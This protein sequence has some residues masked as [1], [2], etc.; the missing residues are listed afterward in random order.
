MAILLTDLLLGLKKE[1]I[2]QLKKYVRS[3]FVTHR[4]D[5]AELFNVYADC[6][7]QGKSF[8]EKVELFEIIY[9]KEPFDDQKMR[10]T[11]SDL[12]KVVE[13][14]LTSAIIQGDETEKNLLLLR[15]YRQRNREKHF[16]KTAQRIEKI[17]ARQ[18]LRNPDYYDDQ[19]R[20][21]SES[22]MF[23][24]TNR[25]AGGLHLQE[26]GDTMDILYLSRKLRHACTQLSHRA[27]F[28]TDYDFGLLNAW[29][30]SLENSPTLK[31]PAV[32]LYYY[33]YLFLTEKE[34]Q[35][36]FRKFRNL[37]SIHRENFPQ[38]ELKNLYRAA[39]NY[40]IRQMNAGSTEFTLEGW[41]LFQEGLQSEIFIENSQLS[42][43][44]FDNVV[45]V[46]LRL[47]KYTAVEHFIEKYKSKLAKNYR[48]DTVKFNFARLEFDRKDYDRA[49]YHLNTFQPA[50]LVNQL[51]TRT[52]LL[53]IY[54]ESGAFDLLDS[55]LNNFR[56]FIR[57]REVSDYHRLNFSNIISFV[58]KE[59]SL[60][61]GNRQE[62][63]K[64]RAAIENE[65]VLTER[66]WLLGNLLN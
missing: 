26:I 31:V 39:I 32:S 34:N 11:M 49:L 29:V 35:E 22:A 2:R 14:Y 6:L 60:P 37:L 43:F 57:R 3:P 17:Q 47:K 55:H 7:Y 51:I 18:P 64:L 50:D 44:T 40:C 38:D 1:E 27:V 36:Y 21:Q 42:R 15:W 62:R 30:H 61:P 13:G 25:R 63:E 19:L 59:L 5:L 12:H 4:V 20:L 10:S 41:N 45:A 54:Y 28:K 24:T 52:L 8:P 46:G 58:K 53:K 16:R 66:A 33:C 65:A 23:E 48:A 56:L 9:P